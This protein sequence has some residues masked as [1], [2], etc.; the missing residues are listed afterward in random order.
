MFIVHHNLIISPY[1]IHITL[2]PFYPIVV[3]GSFAGRPLP[4]YGFPFILHLRWILPIEFTRISAYSL[5]RAIL[6]QSLVSEIPKM[7]P[8][9]GSPHNDLKSK[10]LPL[11]RLLPSEACFISS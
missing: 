4:L 2:L 11:Y 3:I 7:T 10:R 5:P 6:P 9:W 8:A 1:P